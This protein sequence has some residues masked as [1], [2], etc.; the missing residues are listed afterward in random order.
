MITNELASD[1][2]ISLFKTFRI[3][4]IRY[5]V[6]RNYEKLPEFNDSKDVDFLIDPG[7]LNLAYKLLLKVGTVLI[8]QRFGFT[9]LGGLN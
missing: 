2:L 4:N 5:A 7:Q 8:L 9:M 6:L 3:N 1:F